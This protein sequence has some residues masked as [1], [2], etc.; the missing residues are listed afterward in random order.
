VIGAINDT[1][2]ENSGEIN[3]L[4]IIVAGDFQG[5]KACD[6]VTYIVANADDFFSHANLKTKQF[7]R[8][9]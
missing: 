4:P 7:L 8:R 2:S 1:L 3:H 5:N 9:I 6:F